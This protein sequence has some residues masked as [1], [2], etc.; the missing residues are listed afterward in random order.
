DLADAYH[1][2]I[3]NALQT[4][5]RNGLSIAM[6]H[7]NRDFLL[8]AEFATATGVRLLPDPHVLSLPT[9][10]FVLSHG[11]ALCTGDKEYMAFRQ[12]VR[13]ADWQAN[14]LA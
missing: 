4:A 6:L 14:F 12:Q 13:Q 11:D 7:G 8:N 9:W 3:A 2:G 1:S 10:Q 5:T